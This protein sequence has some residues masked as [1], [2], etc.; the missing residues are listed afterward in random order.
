MSL[1]VG[2]RLI[3]FDTPVPPVPKP[4]PD[5]LATTVKAESAQGPH[6]PI[7][8]AS[9]PKAEMDA[10]VAENVDVALLPPLVPIN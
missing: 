10:T 5:A 4:A 6:S 7:G 8:D 3:N 9:A 1:Q 2:K